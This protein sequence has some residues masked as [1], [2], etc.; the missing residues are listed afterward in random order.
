MKTIDI[1]ALRPRWRGAYNGSTT[2][3]P[4]DILRFNGVIYRCIM[5]CVEILPTDSNHFELLAQGSDTLTNK[6]ELL[7]FDGQVQ[8]A[9]PAGRNGE[10]LKMQNGMPEWSLQEGRVGANCKAIAKGS[11]V[12]ASRVMAFL[13]DD[14]SIRCSGEGANFGNGSGIAANYYIPQTVSIDPINPP[15]TP[16]NAIYAN[17]YGFYATTEDGDVYSWGY[18]NVGQLGHGDLISRPTATLISFFRDNDIKIKEVITPYEQHNVNTQVYFLTFDGEVYGVGNNAHGQLGDGTV[19]NKTIPVRCGFLTGIK[20]LVASCSYY[21]GM[22]ALDANGEV[23][24]WGYNGQGALG[25]GDTANRT[26]P[27]KISSVSNIVDI[28]SVGGHNSANTAIFTVSALLAADGKVYACGSNHAGILGQGDVVARTGFVQVQTDIKAKKIYLGG[29]CYAVLAVV[30]ENDELYVCG[31]NACGE[32]GLGDVA[33]RTILTKVN[34]DFIDGIDKIGIFGSHNGTF[35]IV[36]DKSGKLWG[37]G[38]NANG[39]IACGSSFAAANSTFQLL[40]FSHPHLGLKS[41]DFFTCG[42]SSDI[43]L[44]ALMDDG[45]VMACGMNNLGQLGT[46]PSNLHKAG[47]LET[48]LF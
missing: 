29:A 43:S 25:L 21:T 17:R 16:F 46:Q 41:I 8:I 28:V 14:G 13:M 4:N 30:D 7:T 20:K 40:A 26:S 15:R 1:G 11:P 19:V 31:G 39:Q 48:V 18:N 6:G 34:A 22:L 37:T 42:I 33:T 24:A 10:F 32:L 23:W 38:Y 5:E 9:I 35:V 3:V 2:Y 12:N 44:F 36:L 47:T 45:R 27:S